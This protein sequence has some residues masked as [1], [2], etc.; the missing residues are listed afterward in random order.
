MQFKKES[1]ASYQGKTRCGPLSR[2]Y[3]GYRWI[4][5]TAGNGCRPF[6]LHFNELPAGVTGPYI[7]HEKEGIKGIFILLISIIH[8]YFTPAR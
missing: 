3:S 8:N 1:A 6:S 5:R 4:L 7:Q 2:D